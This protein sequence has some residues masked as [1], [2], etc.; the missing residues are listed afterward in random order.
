MQ[1]AVTSWEQD[2]EECGNKVKLE[3]P[4]IKSK[5]GQPG[6]KVMGSLCRS[7]GM[8]L[9]GACREWIKAGLRSLGRSLSWRRLGMN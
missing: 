2:K 1:Y 5:P 7:L 4:G 9:G 8:R 6:S 3:E